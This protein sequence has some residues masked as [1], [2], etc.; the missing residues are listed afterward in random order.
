MLLRAAACGQACFGQALVADAGIA[1]RQEFP[2]FR[3]VFGDEGRHL[4]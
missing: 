3:A 4:V 1:M 2:Y